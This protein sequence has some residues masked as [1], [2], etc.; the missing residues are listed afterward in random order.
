VAAVPSDT[1]ALAGLPVGN[2]GA[3]GIDTA[4][5]FVSG[6]ARILDARPVALFD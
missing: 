4:G 3:D 1:Y 6:N 5:D 2:V